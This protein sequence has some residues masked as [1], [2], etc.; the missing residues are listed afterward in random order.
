MIAI[1]TIITIIAIGLLI[2]LGN[3]FYIYVEKTYIYSIFSLEQLL[4]YLLSITAWLI[5]GALVYKY[6]F[7][8]KMFLNTIVTLA[9]AIA[10]TAY[11]FIRV[12]SQ[13]RWF[14]AIGVMILQLSLL[15]I[16]FALL[17]LLLDGRKDC[18][19]YGYDD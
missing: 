13:T 18:D 7:S 11:Q 10:L 6:G 8:D 17:V 16:G 15:I 9:V 14:I 3:R 5:G 12:A 2:W 19:A 1:I 4:I